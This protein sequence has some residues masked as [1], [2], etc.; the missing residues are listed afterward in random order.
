MSVRA[1]ETQAWFRQPVVLGL[2]V[3]AIAAAVFI[4]AITGSWIYDDHSLVQNNP[5]S[6]SLRWWPRWF[7][8]DFWDVNDE[9]ARLGAR[10]VYWRPLISASYAVD[11][12]LGGGSPVM[13]HVTNTLAHAAAGG[14]AFVV[15]RRWIGAA[16]PACLAAMLFAVHPTKAE[17][18]AWIAGRTDVVCMIAI[19]VAVQ[20]VSRRLN[21][22]PGGLAL[23]VL[24]TALAYMTKEQAIVLPAFVAIEAW[25]HVGRPA[26]DRRSLVTLCRAALPQALVAV[27][28]LALRGAVLPMQ[29]TGID[30]QIGA[31]DHVQAVLETF[32]RFV[33]LT[34]A[35]HD[36]SIQQGLVQVADGQVL[37]SMPYMAVGVIS[38]A[39]LIALAIASRHR[40]PLVTLGIAFYLVTLTPTA[41]FVYT[42]MITLVSE[43]FL[44]LPTFGLVFAIG[45]W[46]ASPGPRWGPIAVL[47]A[48]VAAGTMATRR[49]SDYADE[50][51]FWA[52]ERAL[53]PESLRVLEF[54]I[55]EA[56]REKRY[57][58]AL[59]LTLKLT[60][61]SSGYQDASA[62]VG[63]A[64]TLALLVPDHDIDSLRRIDT[65][66]T[67][68]LESKSPAAV[69]EARNIT[70]QIPTQNKPYA[71][72]L[73]KL[74]IR[75]V[76][77][78]SDIRSRLG[79][80]VGAVQLAEQQLATCARCTTAVMTAA[81]AFARAGD[82][83]RSFA[84][85]DSA[86]E[87]GP[88]EL[89]DLLYSMIQRGRAAHE[90][91]L[92]SN[93]PSQLRARAAELSALE[94]WGRAYDVLAPYRAAIVR[95]PKFVVGFAEL[96]YR[97]GEPA[98]AREALAASESEAEIEARVAAWART[99]G[100]GE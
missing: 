31:L 25:M 58:T 19:L 38:V 21:R 24:G 56:M 16:V 26:I 74:R 29:P 3:A 71:R 94:L 20:G 28:Y 93:G 34:F 10:L 60:D 53:H 45:G 42:D 84:V 75:I 18:V 32:G 8:T 100:W 68:L 89:V 76:A 48:T 5:Y 83:E 95:A 64:E 15:L 61:T 23:E 66:C 96:A 57:E 51:V 33:T 37:H 59:R 27:A 35:P 70:F 36:L 85:L 78:Q 86:R 43:R 91:V 40:L 50:R 81:L 90:D 22:K 87:Y 1:N 82:Y 88:N 52:H 55:S 49:A 65:F 97:A 63:V 92:A 11:W 79:D 80:D 12:R 54:E 99:M 30:S 67:D 44:Y 14:L 13:F 77:V 41:N 6:H 4:P 72:R 73:A 17:S 98:V 46:L 39:V 9:S 7:L 47:V 62:A 2:L 69:L